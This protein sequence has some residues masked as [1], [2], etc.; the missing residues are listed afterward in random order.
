MQA[1]LTPVRRAPP[2]SVLRGIKNVTAGRCS[3]ARLVSTTIFA[4]STTPL[5]S[6]M[7][8]Y[9]VGGGR[10]RRC[11]F[12]TYKL[13]VMVT[14]A[15]NNYGPCY[16]PEKLIPLIS[17]AMEDKPLPIYADGMQVR[18]WLSTGD[19]CR[20]ILSVLEKG[21]EGEIYNVGATDRCQHRSG[22]ENSGC[23]G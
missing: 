18:D 17:N 23:D 14:R 10:S 12:T 6:V 2:P 13:P 8:A 19:H 7:I 3:P 22:Q 4:F 15:S 16:F 9:T 21:R 11:R 5:W 20:A 1:I